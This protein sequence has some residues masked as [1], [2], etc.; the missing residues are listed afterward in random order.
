MGDTS[1]L[2][3]TRMIRQYQG[4]DPAG[5]DCSDAYTYGGYA[6]TAIEVGMGGYGIYKARANMRRDKTGERRLSESS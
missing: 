3:I 6:A 1:S 4:V 2:G 5:L